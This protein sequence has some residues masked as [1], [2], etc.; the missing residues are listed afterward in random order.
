MEFG[1]ET[2]LNALEQGPIEDS[3]EFA[4]AHHVDHNIV[5]GTLNSLLARNGVKTT[6]IKRQVFSLTEEAREVL[7]LGSPEFRLFQAIKAEGTTKADLE[8]S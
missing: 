3:G 7:Q 5:V 8:V 1:D 6:E 4:A 2:I